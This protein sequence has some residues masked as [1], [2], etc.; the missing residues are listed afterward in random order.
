MRYEV[1]IDDPDHFT[2]PWKMSMIL[3]KH[4][5]PDPQL[6]EFQCIPFADEFRYGTLYKKKPTE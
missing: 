5:E 1:T 2:R 4:V 6:L 3:Y